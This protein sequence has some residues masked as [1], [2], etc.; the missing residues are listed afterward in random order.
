MMNKK[1]ES[2]QTITAY[3]DEQTGTLKGIKTD[4]CVSV[5]HTA[6][7]TEDWISISYNGYEIVL[8]RV[9]WEILQKQ[10]NETLIEFDKK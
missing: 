3:P 8:P 2:K 5:E 6:E 1:L 4:V 9:N 10:V 7:S